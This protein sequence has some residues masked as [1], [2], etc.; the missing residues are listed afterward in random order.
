M[1]SD[2]TAMQMMVSPCYYMR[3]ISL[4]HQHKNVRLAMV[5]Y[6][7]K[8]FLDLDSVSQLRS[9]TDGDIQQ[10]VRRLVLPALPQ[11][12][13]VQEGDVQHREP[14]LQLQLVLQTH[15]AANNIRNLLIP[16]DIR[17]R[18]SITCS[19]G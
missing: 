15:R 12:L 4:T 1:M 16:E 3:L 7:S 14:L 11:V 2:N 19:V 13:L 9:L 5:K 6:N 17:L 10:H 18:F 8:L